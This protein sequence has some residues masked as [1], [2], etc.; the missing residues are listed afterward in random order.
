MDILFNLLF[1][2]PLLITCGLI[3]YMVTFGQE[4]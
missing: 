4:E 2:I 1:T 3:G